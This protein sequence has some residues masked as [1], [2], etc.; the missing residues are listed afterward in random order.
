[1][2]AKKNQSILNFFSKKPSTPGGVNSPS[3]QVKKVENPVSKPS[4]ANK[5]DDQK[6]SAS[7]GFNSPSQ[8]VK[9]IENTVSKP[10][11]ANENGDQKENV[12]LNK[13]QEELELEEL[14]K[15]CLED[16]DDGMDVFEPVVEKK[17]RKR[18][19]MLDDSS[20]EEETINKKEN[21]TPNKRSKLNEVS[22]NKPFV[23]STPKSS[24]KIKVVKEKAN[25]SPSPSTSKP[26]LKEK[27]SMFASPSLNKSKTE[28]STKKEEEKEETD[29][30]AVKAHMNYS[31]LKPG[32]IMDKKRRRP[33]DP[34]YD[35]GTLYVPESF[36]N[37]L[38]PGQRQWWVL[39]SDH[40]DK[41]LFFKMGKFYELFHMGKWIF[42]I[43][44][45][46]SWLKYET[47][48]WRSHH[49]LSPG[50]ISNQITSTKF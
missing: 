26:A 34:N 17:K 5:N 11:G 3:Q 45:L 8:Q 27:L 14:T 31:F 19:S 13:S 21:D 33:D 10:I 6:P 23:M 18:I 15:S 20:D 30:Y 41:V 29:E 9:K 32:K 44:K 28:M 25:S 22:E 48:C 47:L 38:P 40:Y 2:S 16:S 35:P 39:K 12:S 50:G 42:I 46:K 1:M 4:W 24:N 37:D 7:G 43:M 36:L 49:C